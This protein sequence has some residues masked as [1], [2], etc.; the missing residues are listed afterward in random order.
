VFP[1]KTSIPAGCLWS[2]RVWLRAD[3]VEHRLF[4][5]DELWFGKDPDFNSIGDASFGRLKVQDSNQ[6]V[7]NAYVGRALVTFIFR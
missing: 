4:G 3:G 1:G 6:Q 2:V 7:Y 5:D